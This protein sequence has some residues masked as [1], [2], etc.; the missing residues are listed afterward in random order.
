MG[1]RKLESFDDYTRALKQKYGLGEGRSYK[2]WL[3]VQDVNSKGVRSPILGLKTKRTH[4]LLSSIE[5][6][7]FFLAEHCDSVIDI[8]EQFPLLPLNLSLRIASALDIKHPTHPI[9]KAPI[10]ITTDFVLTRKQTSGLSYEAASIKP[11]ESAASFQDMAKVEIERVWWE[12]LGIRLSLF[13]GNSVTN[14]QSRNISWA[15][16]PLRDKT[17][18]ANL[19]DLERAKESLTSGQYFKQDLC[20]QISYKTGKD[21][22]DSLNLLRTLIATKAIIIDITYPLEDFKIIDILRVNRINEDLLI[23]NN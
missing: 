1:K 16:S 9:T 21:H 19:E 15:T 23:G 6:E 22:I 18:V 7:F 12:L 5:S 3:R 10:I 17:Y 8:R 20:T 4:H 13:T 11:A 2:P 14:A